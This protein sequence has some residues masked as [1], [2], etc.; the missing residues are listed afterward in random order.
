MTDKQKVLELVSYPLE[1]NE[2]LPL[3]EFPLLRQFDFVRHCFTTRM[4]GV[5]KEHLSSLNL[6]Y[7]RGDDRENVD[8][9]YRRLA[10]ALDVTI[11][12]FVFTDQTHTANVIRVGRGD[13][14]NGIVRERPYTDVDGLVTNETG[15]V[16]SAFFADC[17]PLY[18]IDPVH[19]AIGLSHSGWRGT[20]KRIGA[21]TLDKM[22]AEFGTDPA[23][24]Y[25]A[26]G[27]SICRNC[28]EVSSDVAEQFAD[29]FS[30]HRDEI[31]TDKGQGK[32]WLDLWSANRIVLT[33]A[34]IVPEHLAITDLCTCC[35]AKL[36]FS[37]RATNG[38][39][40]NLGAFMYIK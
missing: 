38:L 25:A 21:R 24:V 39:R 9:N 29:E 22:K 35:N 18:F 23:D 11:S 17:V 28:Y 8:E 27:P 34:G 14:G 6:S 36:L 5:S 37:H 15:V 16:L 4:G 13:R 33:E 2:D 20:V 7:N 1:N 12:D 19:K 26:I 10:G 30:G 32:Y 40:G 31:I 3:I